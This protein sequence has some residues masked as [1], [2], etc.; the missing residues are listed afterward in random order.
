M[1]RAAACG[2]ATGE[3]CCGAGAGNPAEGDFLRR[4]AVSA[5]THADASDDEAE[6]LLEAALPVRSSAVVP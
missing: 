3:H 5:S 1:A 4:A 2:Q 6:R